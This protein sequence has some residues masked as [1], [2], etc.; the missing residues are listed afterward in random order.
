[1][2]TRDRTLPL[3]RR[4]RRRF[5]HQLLKLALFGAEHSSLRVGRAQ[6]RLLA[7]LGWRLRGRE[8]QRAETNLRLAFPDLDD[9]E[10]RALL[11]RSTRLLGENLHDGLAA[12]ALLR[13]PGFLREEDLQGRPSLSAELRT[14]AA[15]GRGVLIL[16]GH[17]GCWELLG[18]EVARQV[19][20]A[21]L[22]KLGVVTGTIHNPAVDRLVQRRRARLGMEVL[23]RE[24]GAGP[25]LRHLR[26][27]GI[28]AVLLDQNT[29]VD[30]IL[31]PFFGRLAPTPAGLARMALRY[32]VPV[33]PVA[34]ARAGTGHEIRRGPVWNPLPDRS[35]DPAAVR[36]FLFWCNAQL[37]IFIRRNPEE[38]VWFHQR[39]QED[40]HGAAGLRP[41]EGT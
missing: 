41:R 36:E 12:P 39:W 15:G 2:T 17:I 31:V 13:R 20:E 1:M 19:Q 40:G 21:R 25:I 10:R 4:A 27:G 6:G 8:R 22:G 26:Q 14:L 38:W 16:T 35:R 11:G 7:A 9:A 34:L 37:E 32:G 18:A 23:P 24:R 28:V 30:N 29:R 3:W 5:Y 33:L